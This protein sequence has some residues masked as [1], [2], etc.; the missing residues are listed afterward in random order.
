PERG[1]RRTECSGGFVKDLQL[2]QS[3][4]FRGEFEQAAGATA[5]ISEVVAVKNRH[6]G[7][8]AE[9]VIAERVK[10]TWEGRAG[11][12]VEVEFCK[13]QIFGGC[14]FDVHGPAVDDV[15]GM[16]GGFHE[17]GFVSDISEPFAD[18]EGAFECAAFEDLGRLCLYETGA[19][20]GFG[21]H[22][23][24]INAFDGAGDSQSGDGRFV[25]DCGGEDGV[26]PCGGEQGA[27]GIMDGDV[28]GV[29]SE[30]LETV[31]DA[32]GAAGASG[33]ELHVHEGEVGTIG[34][35]EPC[36]VIRGNDK[37][38]LADV[39]ASHKVFDGS[40]PDGPTFEVQKGLFF[41]E[42]SHAAAAACS[43]DYHSELWHFGIVPATC[44]FADPRGF[45]FCWRGSAW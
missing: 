45:L 43:R 24:G 13:S 38:D 1:F 25:L 3:G 5:L 41:P 23:G 21:D 9:Q 40:H 10:H 39:G 29:R 31:A 18:G 35:T 28:F 27:G 12:C 17:R 37:D 11:E 8:S 15:H 4:L 26:N 20:D 33:G 16:P 32:F 44:R 2:S 14:E 19:V 22:A 42:P 36:E 7:G 34:F 30:H 6:S